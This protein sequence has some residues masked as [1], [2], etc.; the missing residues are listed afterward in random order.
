MSCYPEERTSPELF[1]M[2]YTVFTCEQDG[3]ETTL[4]LR[5]DSGIHISVE[6]STHPG[7]YINLSDEDAQELVNKINEYLLSVK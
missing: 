3:Y 4:E 2:T 6:N 1:T 5:T 7:S